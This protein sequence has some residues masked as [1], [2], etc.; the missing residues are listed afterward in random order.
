MDDSTKP[1]ATVTLEEVSAE[2]AT[3]LRRLM[4][5]YLYDLGSIDGWHISAEGLY[6]NAEHIE[7]FW[8]EPGRRCFLIRVDGELAGFALIRNEASIAG[9][10]THEVSEFFVL[11]K[12][13][14]RGVGE[15]AAVQLFDMAPGPWELSQM[16]S[17]LPAQAFWRQVIGRYTGGRFADFDHAHE[18]WGWPWRGR[19]QRFTTPGARSRP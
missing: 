16:A 10:G 11:R 9:R 12:F 17:N 5:L 14:R 19:V 15:R 6:G 7:R 8:A 3:L 4:Q 2:A 1:P 18:L 13:R